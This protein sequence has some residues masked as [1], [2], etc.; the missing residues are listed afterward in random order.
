M[1]RYACRVIASEEPPP[2]LESRWAQPR[3]AAYAAEAHDP[4]DL[5]H[6]PFF[7]RSPPPPPKRALAPAAIAAAVLSWIPIASLAAIFVGIRGLSQTKLGT[8]RGRSLATAAIVVG[9]ICTIG[10]ATAGTLVTLHY[11]GK[12]KEREARKERHFKEKQQERDEEARKAREEA[13]DRKAASP[14]PVASAPPPADPGRAPPDGAPPQTRTTTIGS[15]VLVD[16]GVKEPSLKDVLLREQ[17]IAKAENKEILVMASRQGCD[18]CAGVAAALP[19]PAMQK[20]LENIRLVRVDAET[21]AEDLGRLQFDISAVPG[22]FLVASDA[23]PR[24]GVNGGEWGA[25]VAQNIAPVLGPFVRGEYK[26]RKKPFR[27]V[28]RNGT[29]L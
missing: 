5:L 3:P 28:R 16:V 27:P 2:D 22:F 10:Y 24:D 1:V 9:T 6:D 20:A 19:D 7:G 29:F 13:K 17:K 23:M 11:V 14:P 18:P 15:I 25:D 4:A 8:L 26:H 21:F 12:A